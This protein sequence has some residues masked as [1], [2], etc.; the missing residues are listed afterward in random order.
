M[1]FPVIAPIGVGWDGDT[2]NVN[3]D[4]A[5][6]AIA[7]ATQAK[8]LLMLTD[9]SG[10]LDKNKQ[11]ISELKIGDI[12]DSHRRWH[13]YRRHDSEKLKVPWPW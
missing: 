9:V 6:G 11:L 1:L 13:G 3:A 10:V 12:P 4:T 5:A 7:T 2:Y 8:R